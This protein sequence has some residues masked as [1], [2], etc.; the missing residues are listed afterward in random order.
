MCWDIGGKTITTSTHAALIGRIGHEGPTFLVG[1]NLDVRAQHSVPLYLMANDHPDWFADN[2]GA[3][4]AQVRLLGPAPGAAGSNR[5]TTEIII[6]HATPQSTNTVKIRR[7]GGSG[8]QS[9]Q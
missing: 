2:N 5:D 6:R 7:G 3:V 4:S 9:T 8:G 1:A